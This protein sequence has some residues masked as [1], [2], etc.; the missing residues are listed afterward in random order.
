MKKKGIVA[1]LSIELHSDW[2]LW[3]DCLLIFDVFQ[4]YVQIRSIHSNVAV[5][6][7]LSGH[8][9][10]VQSLDFHPHGN[11]IASGSVDATVKVF[12]CLFSVLIVSYPV[13]SN[14]CN[15]FMSMKFISELLY[16]FI[17]SLKLEHLAIGD[18][19][20]IWINICG[21]CCLD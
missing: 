10:S 13:L 3:Y 21:W 16:A 15:I 7:A 14:W 11:F 17:F 2:V 20:I 1:W 12:Y 6:R 18:V 8:T 4:Q 5:A 19:Q 9:A